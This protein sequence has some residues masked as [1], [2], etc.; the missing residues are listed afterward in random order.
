MTISLRAFAGADS[1]HTEAIKRV[2]RA[3]IAK[4][5]LARSCRICRSLFACTKQSYH[6][7]FFLPAFFL[8]L[9]LRSIIFAMSVAASFR[10]LEQRW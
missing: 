3:V 5:P 9:A 1:V 7:Y 2:R 6:Y 4:Q 8:G 10:P